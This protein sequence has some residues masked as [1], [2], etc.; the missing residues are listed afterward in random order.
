VH[1]AA[2]LQD[3]LK[4][5]GIT[6]F[7]WV[8]NQSFDRDG[9]S[10]PVLIERGERERPFLVEVREQHSHR[11]AVVQWEPIE[12]VGADLLLRLARGLGSLSVLEAI[13]E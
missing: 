3:D 13:G 11:M 4:R 10:D 6:P 12:P 1:E 2:R 9:F 5:A 7:A 8:V